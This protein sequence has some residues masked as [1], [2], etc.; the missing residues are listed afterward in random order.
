MHLLSF[1]MLIS[2]SPL[3]PWVTLLFTHF[4]F[5]L[6]LAKNQA[7]SS[8][9][10]VMFRKKISPLLLTYIPIPS[11]YIYFHNA[12]WLCSPDL[13]DSSHHSLTFSYILWNPY[14]MITNSPICS[15]ASLNISCN[16]CLNWNQRTRLMTFSV[17][18]K[19][20][21]KVFIPLISRATSGPRLYQALVKLATP[22]RHSCPLYHPLPLLIPTHRRWFGTWFTIFP[23]SS[24]VI[25]LGN[26]SIHENYSSNALNSE[27]TSF[28]SPPSLY[29]HSS[30][31]SHS[32]YPCPAIAANSSDKWFITWSLYF[33]S[34]PSIS[35]S[36][37]TLQRVQDL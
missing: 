35:P 8:Q 3:K 1:I 2:M 34:L 31:H 27:V 5:T 17:S 10:R 9:K 12:L 23:T 37:P 15:I 6:T 26:F 33:Q 20:K 16:F 4:L 14:F 18:L 32:L 13:P 24:L 29:P 22:L 36:S 25:I 19:L 7:I 30:T 21:G 11:S 28:S